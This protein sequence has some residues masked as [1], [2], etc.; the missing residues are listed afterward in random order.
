[1]SAV[2]AVSGVRAPD[3]SRGHKCA[4]M[5]VWVVR[6]GRVG[7]SASFSRGQLLPAIADALGRVVDTLLEVVDLVCH[8]GERI[9]L[10]DVEPGALL[11]RCGILLAVCDLFGALF[12]DRSCRRFDILERIGLGDWNINGASQILLWVLTPPRSLLS[13]W[14]PRRTGGR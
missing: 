13:I 5:R 6:R 1:M 4:E 9:L 14:A 2:G 3:A 7:A 10:L 8:T 12:V 11:D